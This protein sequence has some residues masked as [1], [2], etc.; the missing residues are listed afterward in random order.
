MRGVAL[1]EWARIARCRGASPNT[2]ASTDRARTLNVPG[3]TFQYPLELL[4]FVDR[5]WK[6]Y[7]FQQNFTPAPPPDGCIAS[8]L[9]AAYHASFMSEE[10]R[11]TRVNLIFA[12]PREYFTRL[13][14][15]ASFP[16][17]LAFLK[18]EP[19]RA[20]TTAEIRRLSP[21]LDPRTTA[22][23]CSWST[24]ESHA[25]KITGTVT[26]GS[27]GYRMNYSTQPYGGGPP[28]NVI[29][30][31][32]GP[33]ALVVRIGDYDIAS[34]RD[35]RV[36]SRSGTEPPPASHQIAALRRA[37]V[38]RQ[39][40]SRIDE[41]NE[42]L[43][44]AYNAAARR[45]RW[46]VRE[47]GHGGC[48]LLV[49]EEFSADRLA[50]AVALKYA[51]QSPDDRIPDRTFRRY[52]LLGHEPEEHILSSQVWSTRA[53]WGALVDHVVEWQRYYELWDQ[54][55]ADPDGWREVLRQSF[56]ARD[57]AEHADA[58]LDD[59]LSFLGRLTAV[60]GAVVITDRFRLV[61]FG[62]EVRVSDV[63]ID[64]VYLGGNERPRRVAFEEFGTRHRSA[65]RLCFA[66]PEASAI[67]VSQDGHA[68][69]VKRKRDRVFVTELN[70]PD[71]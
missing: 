17:G 7:E 58:R 51:A 12:S 6:T 23:T 38:D 32:V 34:L 10:G 48:I 49:P 64:H 30:S 52:R 2:S 19:P 22:V 13:A 66:L 16:P 39:G 57:R 3:Q 14:D 55:D 24:S 29:V 20:L 8:V 45:L 61:G 62:A 36:S 21:A 63:P 69:W 33:G 43:R 1:H 9:E 27:S 71:L 67:V 4:G 37:V 59:T 26:W 40:H 11:P 35:G 54:L 47:E 28:A 44:R 25:V 15:V 70:D 46:V 60:D 50:S 31:I 18:L 65:F 41:G 56:L 68:R 53:T 42:Y 5:A